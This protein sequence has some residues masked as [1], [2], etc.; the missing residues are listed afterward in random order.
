MTTAEEWAM[1]II[2][3]GGETYRVNLASKDKGLE[4]LNGLANNEAA[5]LDFGS[6]TVLVFSKRVMSAELTLGRWTDL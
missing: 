2:L 3:E 1:K 4:V 5:V 6:K